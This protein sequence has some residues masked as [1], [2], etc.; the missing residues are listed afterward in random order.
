MLRRKKLSK[1]S[2]HD[3]QVSLRVGLPIRNSNPTGGFPL[4]DCASHV[5]AI[6]VIDLLDQNLVES[7]IFGSK[8]NNHVNVFD[9]W[10]RTGSSFR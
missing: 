7:N 6:T 8:E 5:H 2:L 3:L 9:M 4:P 1:G 10:F